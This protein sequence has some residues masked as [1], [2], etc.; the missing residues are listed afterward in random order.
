MLI[1][2]F[3]LGSNAVP[4]GIS[5]VKKQDHKWPFILSSIYILHLCIKRKI[6]LLTLFPFDQEE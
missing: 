6:I 2:L 3:T 4:I 1:L 5:E